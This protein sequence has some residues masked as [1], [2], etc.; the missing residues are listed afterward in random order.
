MKKGKFSLILAVIIMTVGFVFVLLGVL[1]F[2]G[3]L[4]SP[5]SDYSEM[6][7]LSLSVTG[8]KDRLWEAG[9]FLIFDALL[10][11]IFRGRRPFSM[12]TVVYI[13]PMYFTLL[14][15][16]RKVNEIP[17]PSF[18]PH[19]ITNAHP[20]LLFV[21]FILE[22]LLAFVLLMAVKGLDDK[23]RKKRELNRRMLEKEGIIK[24]KESIEE[25][26]LLDRER[27]L[28][29][30]EDK[31][32]AKEEAKY[33]KER[34]RAE[35]AENDAK[36]KQAEKDKL[37][38]EKKREK[39]EE[40][41][42]KQE[43]RLNKKAMKE[44]DRV[45]E[46]S[47]IEKEK[48]DAKAEKIRKKKAIEEEKK[49]KAIEEEKRRL[50]EEEIGPAPEYSS[51]IGN[52][53]TPLVFP[54]F[55][56]MPE[57]KTIIKHNS[58][59]EDEVPKIEEDKKERIV[60]SSAFM[61]SL[62]EELDR[63]EEEKPKKETTT[64]S[65]FTSG[66]M[67]EAALESA[68]LSTPVEYN[69]TRRPIIGLDDEEE[70]DSDEPKN[71]SSFAPS[72]LPPTHPR[73]RYFENL[74]KPRDNNNEEDEKE[75]KANNIAPSNLST[76]HPRYRYFENLQKPQDS[77]NRGNENEERTNNI[78][79]S[80]LP[81]TH[82]RY[83]YFEELSKK[84]DENVE[85][86]E[87]VEEKKDPSPS[88]LPPS[89]PR[90][91]LFEA[92]ENNNNEASVSYIP[93]R[94][95]VP[96][97]QEEEKES[98]YEDFTPK[99]EKIPLSPVLSGDDNKAKILEKI[100]AS[101]REE[102]LRNLQAQ[103][104]E[105]EEK[106]E[107]DV[108]FVPPS[109]TAIK[110]RNVTENEDGTKTMTIKSG[111]EEETDFNL[112][113]GVGNLASNIAG[114]TAIEMR[115][116]AKYTPPLPSLLKEY[117]G[118][119][120]EIDEYSY[121]QGMIIV[122]T[123]AEQK[124]VVELSNIIKGPTVTMYELKLAQGMII[125][126]IK[127]REDELNY[128]LGGKKIRILAPVPGK[129]AVG[130][131]VP[132][133]KTSIVGFKDMIEAARENPGYMK[134]KL[135]M[136]LGRTIT[137]EPILI[138][139]AKMPHMIIAGTTGSGKSVCINSL[140]NTI[141]YQKS[142]KEVRLIM[143]DPK[144]V[145]L[146]VYD[147]IPHLLTPVITEA[148]RAIKALDWLVMEMERRYAMLARYGVRNVAGLNEK[149]DEGKVTGVEKVPYI[150]LIMDEFA[151]IMAVV[152]K[153]MDIA[154]GRI[155][156]KARAAGIHMI[157]ATQRPSNDVITGTL[158]SNLPGRIAFAVSSGI[159]SRVILDETGAEN[160]LGKG[161]MLLLDPSSMGTK[162]I[163]GAF[164]SDQEVE[165]VSEFTRK[166]NPPAE[167]LEESI[168]EEE[169]DF[170]DGESSD[171]DYDGGD[172]DLY[173]MAKK[174]VFERHSASASYLQRRL[175]IGYNRA[176]RIVEMMEEDGIVGPANGSKPREVLRYD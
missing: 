94:P 31:K 90:R 139:V 122:Q 106:S 62:K 66:G 148:K 34:Q 170:D 126:K 9:A 102:N 38:Y 39:K 52:P 91:K 158:K 141:I 96:E 164:M 176:A 97:V 123:L 42:E 103:E 4:S 41:R 128:A 115:Q 74:Q 113:V 1:S 54:D 17:F 84:R 72:N 32:R 27:K 63:T 159:N 138:D 60:E 109:A 64:K 133:A 61:D 40:G 12:F 78:A 69:A 46:E 173:E 36:A 77:E 163:Q 6:L 3:V 171:E 75:E 87:R 100:N 172:G 14:S 65:R 33:E 156:A 29:A 82:P 114:Y 136:V 117:P 86:N 15:A 145:E 149:I 125:S 49:R 80:N 130:I 152:G 20:G 110:T 168:F 142:P 67:L 127:A 111:E 37:R 45:L 107:E 108:S 134:M 146:T 59:E 83:K 10:I 116:K 147:G 11:L 53:N 137:G 124:I 157:L 16:V 58:Y 73:Y 56:P 129:Q 101:V 19:S 2:L 105:E 140:I 92:L 161:D 175:K 50:E 120:Q 165:S 35:K 174:I 70:K 47:Q 5:L 104:K 132:N 21:L 135:P 85:I 119:S 18:L 160:L 153:E 144:V 26:R 151:D 8:G 143:V 79:P 7:S 24:T 99:T 131:E 88:N 57:L 71:N 154:I 112:C 55:D 81:P 51:G 169:E 22:M 68:A 25:E 167:F 118:I 95:F 76:D 23:W 121:S 30:M 98:E 48:I 89:H 13:W 43:K 28:K 162:R 93:Q 44:K 155:A 150:L 166:N